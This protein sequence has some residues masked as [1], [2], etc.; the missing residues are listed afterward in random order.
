VEEGLK[1]QNEGVDWICL[2]T[3][4]DLLRSALSAGIAQ[5]KEG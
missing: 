2:Q 5:L 3:D 4:I 1:L